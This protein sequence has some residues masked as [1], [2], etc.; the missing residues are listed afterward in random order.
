MPSAAINHAGVFVFGGIFH[1]ITSLMKGRQRAFFLSWG[2][3][4]GF[5]FFDFCSGDE[6]HRVPGHLGLRR[7]PELTRGGAL[8]TSPPPS[9]VLTALP[10][11]G[12]AL[13]RRPASYPEGT[14][15]PAPVVRGAERHTVASDRT[16]RSRA[17]PCPSGPHASTKPKFLRY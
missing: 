6:T 16:R 1:L 12:A 17:R 3:S 15:F 14:G 11:R 9:T 13:S 10:G 5:R 7:S 8:Q 4:R 2:V